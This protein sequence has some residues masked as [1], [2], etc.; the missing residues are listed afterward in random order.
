MGPPLL[1]GAGIGAATSLAMGKSPFMG[2]LLGGATGGAFGGAGGFGSGFGL[3]EGGFLSGLQGVAPEA[4][5]L[6]TGGYANLGANA[7]GNVGGAATGG[8]DFGLNGINST[9]GGTN[10][11]LGGQGI[12]LDKFYPTANFTDEGLS[13]ADK[14]LSSADQMFANKFS[15]ETNPFALDPR[16]LAVNT[17]LSF[18]EKLSDV[19]SNIFSYGK[20]NPMSVLGGANT[21]SN[22]SS[23]AAAQSQQRLNDAIAKGQIP[24]KQGDS[25][26]IQNYN[27]P[28]VTASG[29]D[30]GLSPESI[31]A[32]KYAQLSNKAFARIPETDK[33]K[34]SNFYTSLIG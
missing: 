1:I 20:E 19:G 26:M 2:A 34:I 5:S 21:L 12:Q 28:L 32:G 29:A 18:G 23:N 30:Y 31:A 4:V 8:I 16:R 33:R 3:G 10:L 13:F 17:P 15:T 24:N 11:S 25:T 14:G 22:M 9:L 7:L 6:G 27:A